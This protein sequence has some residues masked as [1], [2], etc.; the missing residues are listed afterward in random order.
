MRNRDRIA[1]ALTRTAAQS[2]HAAGTERKGV[3]RAIS[4]F[5]KRPR[6]HPPGDGSPHS[7]EPGFASC[8]LS[9]SAHLQSGLWL[10]RAPPGPGGW[11]PSLPG[12][13]EPELRVAGPRAR[14]GLSWYFLGV[15]RGAAGTGP[16]EE[17]WGPPAMSEQDGLRWGRCA[18]RSGLTAGPR[19]P[20]E[21]GPHRR[22]PWGPQRPAAACG[23]HTGREEGRA[24]LHGFPH[25]GPRRHQKRQG[26]VLGQPSRGAWWPSRSHLKPL[27]QAWPDADQREKGGR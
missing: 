24:R 1:P 9:P 21:L 25:L 27:A 15:S 8:R 12:T 20:R 6:R 3:K 19:V 5:R 4:A 26:G 13:Q 2:R 22:G 18:R 16:R 17:P 14:R 11:T 23:P 10:G 7:P